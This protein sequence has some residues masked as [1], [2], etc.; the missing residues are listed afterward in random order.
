M[1]SLHDSRNLQGD[2]RRS[3]AGG[4]LRSRVGGMQIDACLMESESPPKARRQHE[5]EPTTSRKED[6]TE[7]RRGEARHEATRDAS[8]AAHGSEGGEA[9]QRRTRRDE[10]DA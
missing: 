1:L 8:P 2:P 6:G 9:S 4:G 5:P 3:L 7:A 10:A